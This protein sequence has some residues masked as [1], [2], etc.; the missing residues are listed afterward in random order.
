[1]ANNLTAGKGEAWATV[2]QEVLREN[3]VGMQISN[4]KFEG[5]FKNGND[6]VHFPRLTKI[7]SLDLA[8]SYSSVTIQNLVEADETFTLDTRKHFAFE[9][10]EEDRIEL[11]VDPQSRAILDGGEAFASDWDDTIMA[12]HANATYTLDDGDMETATNGGAGNAVIL[13]KSNIYDLVTAAVEIM[14]NN[15]MPDSDR[16]MVVSPAEFRLL[17]KSDEF[18]PATSLGDQTARKGFMGQVN[19]VN[20][21]KSNNLVTASSIKHILAGAGAGERA[22]VSFAANIRPRVEITSSNN[23]DSFADLVKAQ[24][25]FGS[26]VFFEGAN[27]L[28]DVNIVG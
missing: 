12:Q 6:T 18:L 9:V 11:R 3:F 10:S 4:T 15:N 2:L 7:Q 24:T 21:I 23:R 1:M 13:S 8:T 17:A 28:I 26:K 20:I 16:F 22:P 5:E 19:G 14:D 27:R 25:K